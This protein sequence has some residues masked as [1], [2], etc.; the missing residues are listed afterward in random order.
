MDW[1]AENFLS[2]LTKDERQAPDISPLYADLRGLPPAL[3][4]C[5]T[6]DPL[7][8]DTLFMEARWRAAGNE[9]TLTIWPEAPHAF[10]AFPIEVARRSLAE[11]HAFLSR[12]S[13]LHT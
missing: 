7:L 4:T 8:D 12:A 2:G 9:A 3:F 1:F 6:A 13:P 11:Q 5:G 10:V